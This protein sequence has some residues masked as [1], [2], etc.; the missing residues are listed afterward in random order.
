MWYI[1]VDLWW[2]ILG[3][4]VGW[5]GM[6]EWKGMKMMTCESKWWLKEVIRWCWEIGK[7]NGTLM[8]F[9]GRSQCLPFSPS[10]LQHHPSFSHTLPYIKRKRHC[11]ALLPFFQ[12]N[13][14]IALISSQNLTMNSKSHLVLPII[15]INNNIWTRGQFLWKKICV[16]VV[17]KKT[18][19]KANWRAW[20]LQL[21]FYSLF[22]INSGIKKKKTNSFAF[23]EKLHH[24]FY[25]SFIVLAND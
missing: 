23:P 10:N 2:L 9:K 20:I 12:T 5:H 4:C 13:S 3:R 22:I 1:C 21:Y 8:H 18:L 25:E 24:F 14:T 7:Q 16:G 19:N 17:L 11:H 6:K 15:K